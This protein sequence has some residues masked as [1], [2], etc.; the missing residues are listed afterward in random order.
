MTEVPKYEDFKAAPIARVK[1]IADF[2]AEYEP[3]KYTI[4]GLLPGGSIYGLT[5]KRGAGKTALLTSAAL[6][7][8][9]GEEKFLGLEVEQGRVAYII[10][11]NPTDFRMKLSA[12]AFAHNVDVGA[13]NDKICILDMRLPH[14]QIMD[15]LKR[16]AGRF[17]PLQLVNYDTFQAGFPGADFNDNT[18]TLKHAQSLREFTT[19]PGSPSVLAACHPVKNAE[20]DR[21]EPYGGGSTMNEF[22]GNITAWNEG[23]I[24]EVGFNKVRGPEFEP[25]YFRIEKLGT[26]DILDI[27]GR[28]PFLRSSAA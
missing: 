28:Q 26:P 10:L 1:G 27:K 18:A 2:L 8:A 3:I 11:E 4:D 9:T 14:E 25:L 5:A 15:L 19:L 22:D 17:G 13:L 6:A 23:G 7:V 16:D 20:K 24:I 12:A 21:L